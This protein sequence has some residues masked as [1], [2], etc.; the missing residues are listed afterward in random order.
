MTQSKEYSAIFFKQREN[1]PLQVAFVAPSSEIDAW[2]RVPTK[3]TGNVRNFQRAEIPSHIQEVQRFFENRD[4]SS[5][6]AIVVGFDPIRAKSR[7]AALTQDRERLNDHDLTPGETREGVVRITWE[8]DRDPETKDESIEALLAQYSDLETYIFDELLDISGG[9]LSRD[10]LRRVADAFRDH[11]RNG[12]LPELPDGVQP[13]LDGASG[14][15]ETPNEDQDVS[16]DTIPAEIRDELKG[17][18]PSP[19]QVVIGRL[20]FLSR[21]QKEI[22]GAMPDSAVVDIYREVCDELKPGILIDGQHRVMGTKNFANI[23][24]LVTALPTA[25]WPELAFQFLVTNRTARRVPES[26]LIAIVGQSLSKEQRS[27]IEERLR[28]ANIRVGLIEA[29]MKVHED[30]QSPFFDMLAFGIKN[31]SGF[32]D[33]AAMQG[34]VI[35]LWYERKAPVRELFDHRCEGKSLSERT[36]FWKSE[37]LWFEMFITFWAAVKQRYEGTSVFSDELLDKNK[38]TPASRLMTATVLKVFQETILEFLLQHLKQKQATE[39]IPISESIPD[40]RTF[41]KLVE[42]TLERLTP[43]FFTE[44]QL[45]GFDGSKGARDDLAD[46]I[47][48]VISTEKTVSQ[49]KLSARPHRLFKA[50]E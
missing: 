2:A 3:K 25:Y 18:S 16:D 40:S 39:G 11:A 41:S 48:K 15:A 9:Q 10:S 42:R 22:L 4:N 32:I 27:V 5:P 37:E 29:V 43:E 50:E 7:V 14:E 21:L 24:F 8:S 26:L 44:W 6:T 13:E 12:E 33:A 1:A 30:E 28:E 46:A 20:L 47:K 36:E 31:E 17:L 45:T 35:Q 49:L 19:K 34:K 38:K 23:P